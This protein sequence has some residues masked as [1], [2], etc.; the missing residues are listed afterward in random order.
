MGE[1]T[2]CDVVNMQTE[3]IREHIQPYHLENSPDVLTVGRRCLEHGYGFHWNPF[4][5][6]P[7]YVTPD[8]DLVEHEVLDYVPY[9]PDEGNAQN[10][11]VIE[12]GMVAASKPKKTQ[13]AASKEARTESTIVASS[14]SRLLLK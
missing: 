9:L 10:A 3:G 13:P 2:A 14:A 6:R 7:Y 4:S 1:V 11:P 12:S 5:T 8:G